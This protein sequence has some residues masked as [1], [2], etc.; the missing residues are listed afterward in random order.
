MKRT[1]QSGFTLMET[2]VTLVIFLI[3]SAIV[4]SGIVQMMS[5][6]GTV[7]NRTEMHSSVRSA[8]E[9]LQQEI[10][11]AGRISLPTA[12]MPVT[13]T[14]GQLLSLRRRRRSP[15]DQFHCEHVHGDAPGCRCGTEF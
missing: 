12:V 4:M 7:A 14:S 15:C 10:G 5:T 13:I 6:Q 3:V 1:R 11:Q 9:L 8:T 2:M